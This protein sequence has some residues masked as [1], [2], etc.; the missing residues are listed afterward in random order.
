MPEYVVTHKGVDATGQTV[1]LDRTVVYTDTEL[2]AKVIG[3]EMLGI[4]ENLLTV[5]DMS[6]APT[7]PNIFRNA[8]PPDLPKG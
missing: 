2:Q 5:T 1:I 8:Q 4:S 3:A 7:N 6:G